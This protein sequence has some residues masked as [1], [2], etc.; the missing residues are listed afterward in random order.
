MK[1]LTLVS[2]AV[3]LLLFAPAAHAAAP[4]EVGPGKTYAKPCAAFAA[5]AQ[6]DTIEIDAAGNG[7]YD[8]DV[9]AIAPNGLTIR[10]VNGR[11]HIDAAGQNAQGKATWVVEGDDITIE[12]IELS[13]ASVPDH[14]GA[15]IR[16]DGTNL[17]IRSCYF[18]DN[19]EGILGGAGEV[20]IE[21]SEFAREGNCIDPAGCAHNMYLSNSVTKFTLR[22]SYTHSATDGHLI[23]SRAQTN[24]ILENRITGEDGTDS[25]EI[26]F[27]NAG[28][29]YVI[30]NLIEQGANTGNP[31]MLTF[32][33][34][35]ASNAGK[36]LYVVN[37]TFVNDHGS[38]T[39]VSVAG[40]VT[41]PAV[42]KN[43]VF[44]GPGT[45][46]NQSGATLANNF[47]G[48]PMLQDR[49]AF[50]YHLLAGS[51]CI[52]AGADPGLGGGFPS[53]RRPSTSI[54]PISR[55]VP[56]WMSSISAPTNSAA[57]WELK[58][59]GSRA[60]VD[61]PMH[62]ALREPEARAAGA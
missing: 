22:Y 8:G 49:A 5:A 45:T 38:G 27:P 60:P 37:N 30:G 58:T 53:R 44:F 17:T 2:G 6:G 48:D 43:N 56:P 46:V 40:S 4:L 52:N 26:D 12:N 9:C 33:E 24:Y 41:T 11:A 36:D 55:V 50:D 59:A 57:V 20:L 42:V 35:G 29:A 32:G 28:T 62:P 34:E 61:P 7:T 54:R 10:G 15:G 18:H 16:A 39:F 3:G 14:N 21:L 13:G 1:R 23:K 47:T 51:P 19:E 25:Y 31:E